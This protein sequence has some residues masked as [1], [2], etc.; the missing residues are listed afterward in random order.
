M[1]HQELKDLMT[2]VYGKPRKVTLLDFR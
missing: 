2:Q 1:T